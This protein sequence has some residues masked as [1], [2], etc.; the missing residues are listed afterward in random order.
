MIVNLVVQLQQLQKQAVR[1]SMPRSAILHTLVE[2]LRRESVFRLDESWQGMDWLVVS[3][4]STT[5]GLEETVIVAAVPEGHPTFSEPFREI[6]RLD[7]SV[8]HSEALASLGC[9]V[10]AF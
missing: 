1:P 3:D 7:G 2:G 4:T 6:A 10:R 5:S 9:R 8:E